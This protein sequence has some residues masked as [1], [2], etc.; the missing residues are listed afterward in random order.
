[1]NETKLSKIS[2]LLS[3]LLGN[4]AVE[5][6]MRM[7]DNL[8]PLDVIIQG[9]ETVIQAKQEAEVRIEKINQLI[10]DATI[11]P[12][13]F[14]LLP[15]SDKQDN[16]DVISLGINTF[17]EELQGKSISRLEFENTLDRLED[18]IWSVSRDGKMLYSNN[19]SYNIFEIT[20]EELY[21]NANLWR[22]F[23]HPDD[24]FIV[25]SSFEQ[26][27]ING[28][29]SYFYRIITPK[30]KTIKWLQVNV[31]AE[32]NEN[33][34][35][36]KIS[37]VTKDITAQK[38]Q[39]QNLIEAQALTKVGSWR[40]LFENNELNWSRETYRI[41]E[42]DENIPSDQLYDAY[43]SK[44][45]IEDLPQLDAII[46]RAIN[47]GVGFEYFH[48]SYSKNKENKYIKGIGKIIK[49]ENN[50]NIGLEG[51]VQDITKE[52]LNEQKLIEAN[53]KISSIVNATDLALISVLPN[54]IIQLFNSG[55]EALLGYQATEIVGIKT[56]E[57]FHVK[58]EVIK[59][60][61]ELSI[62]LNR[63]VEPGLDTFHLK[64][65]LTQKS[66]TNRWTYV[67]KNGSHIPVELTINAIYDHKNEVIGFIGIAKDISESLKYELDLKE[68][69]SKLQENFRSLLDLKQEIQNFFDLSK[70]LMCIA[71]TDGTFKEVNKA[72]ADELG[73]ELEKMINQ[74][75]ADFI[76]PD[77]LPA[78]GEALA[79]LERGDLLI[80]F[81]NR[82]RKADG[83]YIWIGWRAAPDTNTG[84]LFATGR[85]VTERKQKDE[86]LATALQSVKDYQ[87]ALNEIAI[88]SVSDIKGDIILAN[89][90]FCKISGYSQEELLGKNHRIVK[91]NLVHK[92]VFENLWKTIS[93]GKTWRGEICNRNKNGEIYWVDTLIVPFI[94][95]RGKIYQYFSIRYDITDRKAQEKLKEQN[96]ELQKQNEIVE[97]KTKLK[98]RFLANM[99]HEIRT[100]MNSILGL[101]NLLEKVGP[102]NN[103]QVEYLKTIR[104]NSNNLLN[105]IND[106]LDLSKIDEGKMTFEKRNINIPTIISNISFSLNPMALEKKLE[107]LTIIDENIP[108]SVL[109][110]ETKLTQIVTNIVNNAIKFTSQGKV[111]LFVKNENLT[112]KNVTI[113]F[114]IQDTGIGIEQNKLKEIFE[115]FTQENDSTT[116]LFGGTGL[117]L[118]ICKKMVEEMGGHLMVKSEVNVGSSFI[119]SL[120]FPLEKE[121]KEPKEQKLLSK[122][123]IYK[124]LLVEDNSFNQMVA[125]DTLLAWNSNLQ[126]TIAENG[127][128]ALENV[129]NN[130]YDVILLDIELPD[131]SGFEVSREIRQKL[132]VHTSIIAMTAHSEQKE[133]DKAMAAGMNDFIS[134]P[135]NEKELFTK[136]EKWISK[137]SITHNP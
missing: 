76:H 52:Y 119:F 14:K 106:I 20:K 92:S 39:E 61:A 118:T 32:K 129:S 104:I 73:Y 13:F 68:A 10:I 80:D 2:A 78:T 99:S 29:H 57:I 85:N 120:T 87:I 43:R 91:S 62:E 111:T 103:K 22:E 64:S 75:F 135:F 127:S 89:D 35:I 17:M 79:Q 82:Y 117:G 37:G 86:E 63:N 30:T 97:Q 130:R 136:L 8:D 33:G 51:T 95:E 41:F 18:S 124:I 60:S 72:F 3:T 121:Q 100:P 11:N 31:V 65:I 67:H 81:E 134:K 109:G 66:D 98:E 47:E 94:D 5:T 53:N 133:L 84:N 38:I 93:S 77:D 34:D 4:E 128:E 70:D 115:P 113:C 19:A 116:R 12:N 112:D 26:L 83:T 48:G 137:Q 59:K 123:E 74:P 105:I 27:A 107:L 7:N 131:I 44:I 102:L 90:N 6:E 28:K 25:D 110:D 40:F 58:E 96:I 24:K 126:I 50:N 36:S 54:G 42:L 125:E 132:N 45:V 15:V 46:E 101:S 108:E 23:V 49:D 88:V 55:A 114:E 122:S 21:A 1:M 69:N 56:P 16:I 71:N 9:L